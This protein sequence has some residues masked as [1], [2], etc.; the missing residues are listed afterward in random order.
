MIDDQRGVA[1]ASRH[2]SFW[3]GSLII[4]LL[5]GTVFSAD[6]TNQIS[7]AIKIILLPD[8]Q[9]I[10]VGEPIYLSFQVQNQSARDLQTIQGGDYRNQLGRPESYAI[11]VSDKQG[12]RC[13]VVDAGPT[14]GGMIGPQKIPANGTWTRRLF[15][16]NW[17]NLNDPGEY[18][19]TCKTILKI[20]TKG[21][22]QWDFRETTTNL[23]VEVETPLHVVARDEQRMG[24]LIKQLGEQMFSK[25]ASDSEEACRSLAW[26]EDERVIPFFNQ[27]MD[28]RSYDLKITALRALAKFK[29]DEAL[30]GLRKGMGTRSCDLG[31]MPADHP[32]DQP[33]CNIRA[34]AA[35]ALAR[36]PHPDAR[37][38]LLSMRDDPCFGVRL[39]VL[40][41]LGK[42]DT[43]ESLDMIRK[44]TEDSDKR[45]CD[46]ALRYLKLRTETQPTGNA[47][48]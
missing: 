25:N 36:S 46:E 42:M 43:P 4:S 2:F 20:R 6:R 13:P 30:V 5:A 33:A 41:T 23:D 11:T 38:L 40:H 47:N 27:A 26:I 21:S 22:G 29:N 10:M 31:T 1:M 35:H 45:I 9:E 34:A 39:G 37:S 3:V 24:E 48:P 44:M 12:K 14:K 15:L 17:V 28:T 18:I 7:D 32:S 16:P 8:K 19:V